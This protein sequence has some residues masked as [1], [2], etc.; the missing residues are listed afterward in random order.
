MIAD[1]K[2]KEL[3]WRHPLWD[4]VRFY[5]SLRHQGEKATWLSRL[6]ESST[7]SVEEGRAFQIDPAHVKL[8]MEYLPSREMAF[9]HAFSQLRLEENALAFCRRNKINIKTTSTR[10]KDHHQSSKAMVA[11][12]SEIAERVCQSAGTTVNPN[13]QRRCVWCLDNGLHVSARNIDGAIPSLANPSIIWEI[14]EYWGKTTGGSKMS[15]AV[16]ECNLVGRELREYEE[17]T[18][19]KVVHVA[20]VDGKI[21]WTARKSDLKRFVDLLN[22]GLID[23]LIIGKEVESSWESILTGLLS[24]A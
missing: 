4:L 19:F 15:D 11:T 21:Q 23:H 14:K 2:W 20:F 18:G 8:F 22:Q 6:E 1:P 24:A 9:A 13:P 3:G 12:V 10:S 7:L 5:L 17:R 16:Y